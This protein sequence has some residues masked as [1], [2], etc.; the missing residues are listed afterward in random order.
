MP[1]AADARVRRH[2]GR[3]AR[4]EGIDDAGAELL[5][6]V[7][8]EVRHPHPVGD[9]ARDAHGVGAAARGLGV[10]LR[11]G[12]Q[13]ERDRDGA[14]AGQQ[15]RHGRVHPAA[16][17]HE[18]PAGV[19]RDGRPCPRRAAE[20]AVQRVGGEVSGVELPRRQPAQLGG[21]RVRAHPRRVEHR[22]AVDQR[23]G[24][25]AGGGER[26]AAGGLEADRRHA[27]ALDPHGEADQVAAR[28]A[29]GASGEAAGDLGAPR[30]RGAQMLLEG[31]GIHPREVRSSCRRTARGACPCER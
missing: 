15:R 14:V 18:R 9:R 12:P 20:R 3:V 17:R 26:A 13:L 5:A 22:L 6:Q 28:G 23:R 2:A 25:R 10:V 1:V 11:V 4:Q 24:R 29:A 30:V 7:E 8:R 16:H 21:D 27:V 31:R 19:G